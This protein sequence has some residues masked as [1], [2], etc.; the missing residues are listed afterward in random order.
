MCLS[1]GLCFGPQKLTKL[2]KLPLASFRRLRAAVG[3]YINDLLHN[4]FVNVVPT[5]KKVLVC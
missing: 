2:L 4:A 3:A 1:S 5:L